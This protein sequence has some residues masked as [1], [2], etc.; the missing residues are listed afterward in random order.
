MDDDDEAEDADEHDSH[1]GTTT[2]LVTLK[3]KHNDDNENDKHYVACW[4]V[5][6]A[7]SWLD[8]PQLGWSLARSVG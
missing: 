2:K 4:Q 3:S 1:G 6:V 8:L 5:C 7:F